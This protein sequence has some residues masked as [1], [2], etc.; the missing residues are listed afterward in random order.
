M[1]KYNSISASASTIGR[2]ERFEFTKEVAMSAVKIPRQDYYTFE[3]WMSWDEDIRAE[4]VDGVLY[5]IAQPTIRH[6]EIVME[7]SRQ[8]ANYLVGK[9]CKVLPSPVGVRL[10]KTEN[11][12]LEPDIVVVCDRSK[13]DGEI[14]NGAPDMVVE[15]LSPSSVRKQEV[16]KL[17]KYQ[18]AGVPEYWIVDPINNVV[19]VYILENGRYNFPVSYFSMDRIKISVLENCEVNLQTVFGIAEDLMDYIQSNIIPQY[20]HDNFDAAHNTEH[21]QRTIDNSLAIAMEHPVDLN[22]VY[23]I[24]AYHDLGIP[25]GRKDHGRHSANILLADRQLSDWFVQ[26]D[27][28]IM[29]EAVEDHRS[30]NEHDP[31]S[32]YGKIICDA[33][34]DIDYKIVLRRCLQYSLVNFLD[35]NQD[36]HYERCLEHMEEKFGNNGYMKMWLN[37][38]HDM[39]SLKEL[40]H[41]LYNDQEGLRRDFDKIWSDLV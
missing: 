29:A 2:N 14:C 16:I 17:K 34:N 30:S 36:E 10:K 5:M 8:I 35:Y 31:R 38:E 12:A 3:D 9:H 27:I 33:D 37:S 20:S 19:R 23:T 24:A 1:D 28:Q 13:L 4:I 15:V 7:I 39:R 18:A 6:Q 22:M 41:M 32:I 40:R 25:L 26:E 11:T 21:I